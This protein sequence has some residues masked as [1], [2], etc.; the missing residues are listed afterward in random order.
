M[1]LLSKFKTDFLVF[2]YDESRKQSADYLDDAGE[3][4]LADPR[5]IELLFGKD[6]EIARRF[7]HFLTA[8]AI[9]LFCSQ[10]SEWTSYGWITKPGKQVP[11]HLPKWLSK[12]DSYWIYHCHTREKFRGRGYY[13]Q[14]LS[15]MTRLVRAESPG[16]PIYIDTLPE[17]TPSRRAIQSTGFAA[18]GVITTYKL[19][20]PHVG[21]WILEGNWA[22]EEPH[23]ALSMNGAFRAATPAAKF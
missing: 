23:P 1:S 12:L 22:Q 9:G 10:G 8:G 21:D 20:I 14:L 11:P 2:R 19:W 15:R 13:K 18:C 16:S 5:N 7:N 6:R 17:N 4:L 3:W